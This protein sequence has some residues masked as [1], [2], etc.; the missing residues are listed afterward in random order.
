MKWLR[1]GRLVENICFLYDLR[2]KISEYQ[3]FTRAFRSDNTTRLRL[4]KA[5]V[6]RSTTKTDIT[7]KIYF[8][9][10]MRLQRDCN[11]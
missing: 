4:S 6:V 11:T 1:L 3:N 9:Y 5:V 8:V 10:I 2:N 7:L